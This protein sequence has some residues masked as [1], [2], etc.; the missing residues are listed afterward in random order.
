MIKGDVDN[1][2]SNNHYICNFFNFT[3]DYSQNN[4]PKIIGTSK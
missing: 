2:H 3:F 4:K 1:A